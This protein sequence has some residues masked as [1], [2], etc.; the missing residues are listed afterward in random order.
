MDEALARLLE[1]EDPDPD[2][3]ADTC[4]SEEEAVE[5]PLRLNEKR[6]GAVLAVLR[7]S[8]ARRVLDL[9]CGSGKL[10]RALMAESQFEE[11]V[12]VD[13]A[14][15]ALEAAESRLR[16]DRLAPRQRERVRLFHGP[17]RSSAASATASGSCRWGPR[18]R[19]LAPRRRWRCSSDDRERHPQA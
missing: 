16:L 8:A 17:V 15:R 11:I 9:G 7:A 13:I 1:D 3:D 5:E 10:I 14:H 4:A 18:T 2:R 19:T 6:L 12:G